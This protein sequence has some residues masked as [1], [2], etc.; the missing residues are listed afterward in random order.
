MFLYIKWL[1]TTQQRS[2]EYCQVFKAAVGAKAKKTL[3]NADELWKN[4]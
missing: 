1:K 2:K 4:E 3:K